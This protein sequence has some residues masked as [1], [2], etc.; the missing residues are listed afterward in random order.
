MFLTDEI[1][2]KA[3]CVGGLFYPIRFLTCK[4]KMQI[5]EIKEKKKQI[6]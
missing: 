1:A 4:G 6:K 5:N 2:R 3:L